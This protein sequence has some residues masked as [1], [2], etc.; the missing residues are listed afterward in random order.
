MERERGGGRKRGGTTDRDVCRHAYT[1]TR[2]HTHARTQ[3]R[4]QTDTLSLW[5]LLLPLH[6]LPSPL[7]P[8]PPPPLPCPAQARPQMKCAREIISVPGGD[9][10]L[11]VHLNKK[12]EMR[13]TQDMIDRVRARCIASHACMCGCVFA[14]PHTPFHSHRNTKHET[15]T[16]CSKRWVC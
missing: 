2:I 3:T 16:H 4:T 5:R 11:R 13:M 1:H 6:L 8:H 9:D 7:S 14:L 12:K 10:T 15:R